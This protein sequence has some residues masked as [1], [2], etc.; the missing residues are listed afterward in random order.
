MS[1]IV[2]GR[3]HNTPDTCGRR[4]VGHQKIIHISGR[5]LRRLLEKQERR[6]AK[7]NATKR[8]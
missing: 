7:K 3:V 1:N 5:R 6:R 8:P 4:M 2:D